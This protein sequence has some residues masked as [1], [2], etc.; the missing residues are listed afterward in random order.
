[1]RK[2]I[3]TGKIGPAFGKGKTND[4]S[5]D[6]NDSK[7]IGVDTFNA[8]DSWMSDKNRGTV[9]SAAFESLAIALAYY[10]EYA[11]FTQVK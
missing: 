7:D 3:L 1:M 11:K 6:I 2:V 5:I 4:L 9:L 8:P 10:P